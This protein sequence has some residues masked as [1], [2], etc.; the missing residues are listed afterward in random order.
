MNFKYA[1]TAGGLLLIFISCNNH[2]TLESN[3]LAKGEDAKEYKVY[4]ADTIAQVS[5]QQ[6][7]GDA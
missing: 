2:S 7:P 6:P 3:D 1:V 4:S 5:H